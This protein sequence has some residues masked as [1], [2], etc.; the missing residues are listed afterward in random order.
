[1]ESL[2]SSNSTLKQNYYQISQPEEEQKEQA[3]QEKLKSLEY[4]HVNKKTYWNKKYYYTVAGTY[5]P[6]EEELSR[7]I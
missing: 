7:C 4:R 2:K 1:M 5:H 6:S 3:Y